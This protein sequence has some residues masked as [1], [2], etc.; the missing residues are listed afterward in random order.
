MKHIKRFNEN[1]QDDIWQ[2][3]FKYDN[4]VVSSKFK[5]ICSSTI[6][7]LM[8]DFIESLISRK[9]DISITKEQIVKAF[10][11]IKEQTEKSSLKADDVINLLKAYQ[12]ELSIKL[13]EIDKNNDIK[14]K[15]IGGKK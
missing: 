2:Q 13:N 15:S 11:H 3:Q 14:L 7:A 8:D 6:R 1:Y 9:V 5:N 10:N 4:N 12:S